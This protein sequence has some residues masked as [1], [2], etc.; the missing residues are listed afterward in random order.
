MQLTNV[1]KRTLL[2]AYTLILINNFPLF[3]RFDSS[4]QVFNTPNKLMSVSEETP[5]SDKIHI[6]YTPKL[7]VTFTSADFGLVFWFYY[8]NMQFYDLQQCDGWKCGYWYSI[9]DAY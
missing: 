7:K 9:S 6:F 4:I 8:L 1:N 2:Y 5:K 3:S